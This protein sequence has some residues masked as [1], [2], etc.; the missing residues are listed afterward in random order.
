LPSTLVEFY[1]DYNDFLYATTAHMSGKLYRDLH[2]NQ[3]LF[4]FYF[5][6]LVESLS[7]EG[8][9]YLIFRLVSASLGFTA[10]VFAAHQ[11][12]S[13]LSMRLVF[14]ALAWCAGSDMAVT[15]HPSHVRNDKID[16]Q[17]G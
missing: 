11:F 14:L 2:Y 16:D 1:F 4:G 15:R 8:E 6:R 17:F 13:S 5:W 10:V 12:L 7:P 3:A 9:S